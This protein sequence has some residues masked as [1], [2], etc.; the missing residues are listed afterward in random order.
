MMTWLDWEP[1]SRRERIS[2]VTIALGYVILMP[3][4]VWF[5][6]FKVLNDPFAE[7]NLAFA[8]LVGWIGAYPVCFVVACFHDVLQDLAHW[9]MAGSTQNTPPERRQA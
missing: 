4:L 9:I 3:V 1:R 7:Q 8:M 6:E 2:V 5:V